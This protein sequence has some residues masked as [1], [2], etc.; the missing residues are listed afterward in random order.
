M[1]ILAIPFPAVPMLS[2]VDWRAGVEDII[3]AVDLDASPLPYSP[4]RWSWVE[5]LQ[6]DRHSHNC[7]V[8]ARGTA[9]SARRPH[10]EGRPI[11]P[12][13]GHCFWAASQKQ[14]SALWRSALKLASS[15]R[16]TVAR[17]RSH[18]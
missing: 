17:V 10:G 8:G 9:Q 14:G 3:A 15:W 6:D 16:S 18:R 2:I 11:C 1:V 12:V 7:P 4:G 5:E 13:R